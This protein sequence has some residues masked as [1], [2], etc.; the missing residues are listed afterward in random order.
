MLKDIPAIM[1]YLLISG[2]VQATSH[3]LNLLAMSYLAVHR[4]GKLH[5]SL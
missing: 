1:L 2:C 5:R 3:L 4:A